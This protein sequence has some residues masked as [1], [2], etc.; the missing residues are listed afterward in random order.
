MKPSK[1]KVWIT[2]EEI[3]EGSVLMG[4]PEDVGEP[5]D[6]GEFATLEKANDARDSMVELSEI[7]TSK[8]PRLR[9]PYEFVDQEYVADDR[10][11]LALKAYFREHRAL[12]PLVAKLLN[13]CKR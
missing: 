5:F 13:L 1:F 4:E 10:R 9:T 3:P 11:H 7:L 12:L 8:L 2:I 6:A